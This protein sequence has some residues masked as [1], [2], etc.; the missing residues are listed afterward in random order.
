M[1]IGLNRA[2]EILVGVE[3]HICAAHR[4]TPTGQIHGHTWLIKAF[5]PC[6]PDA[7]HLIARL[8]AACAPLNETMLP[9]HL[10]R[11]EDIAAYLADQL[12]GCVRIEVSRG[13]EGITAI[14]EIGNNL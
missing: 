13:P 1:S 8:R 3:T 5:W 9:D 12:D 14:W 7:D 4:K 10:S 11:N 2:A 6:G